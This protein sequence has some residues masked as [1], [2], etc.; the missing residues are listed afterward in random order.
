MDDSFNLARHVARFVLLLMR[1]PDAVDQQK[2]ELRA[3]ALMTKEGTVRLSTREG[4]LV[5]N[6][7][8]VPAVL[9]GVRELADQMVGHQVESLE[10]H[11][12]MSPGELLNTARLLAEPITADAAEF[13]KRAAALGATTVTIAFHEAVV[14]EPGAVA[15]PAEPEPAP[16]TPERI[17][18]LLERANRAPEGTPLASDFEEVAFAAEQ[19]TRE[20]RTAA[21]MDV[22]GQLIANE[23]NA[24][25]PE[26]R[27]QFVLTIRRLTKPRILQPVAHLFVH[28]AAHAANAATILTRCGT[29][30]ADAVVDQYARA[31]TLAE[32]EAIFAAF[33]RLPATD[34]SLVAMLADARPH[35]MRVAAELLGRRHPRE[36]DRALAD[37]LTDG[38]VH[39]RRA[40]VR[41]LAGFDTPFAADAI[42]R[43]LGDAMVEVRLEAVSA[44]AR[45]GAP[46]AVESIL[47]ALESEE[48]IEVQVALLAALGKAAT[49]DAVARLAKVAEAGSGLFGA[50]KGAAVRVAAVH[51]LADARTASARTALLALTHDKERE[52][53]DAATRAVAR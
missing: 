35:I 42:A 48:E 36:A 32:R 29:D 18:F 46:R 8:S 47:R 2:L 10:V 25:D 34:E 45:R 9:A 38:D 33:D 39:S 15:A 24:T 5:A 40:A 53:R 7:L 14:A 17:A 43:G 3:I 4:Q 30:G 16:G 11:Q 6:G 13:R 31:A 1:Q 52:V 22:F 37:H 21:A 23:A 44:L 28:D 51:A 20:G 27:R 41:A 12:G 50:R 26:V 49:P 19:A